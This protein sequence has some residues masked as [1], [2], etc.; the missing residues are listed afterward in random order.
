MKSS[1][2]MDRR[3]KIVYGTSPPKLNKPLFSP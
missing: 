1:G 3:S 2:R